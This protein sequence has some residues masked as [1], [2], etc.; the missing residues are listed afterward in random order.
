MGDLTLVNRGRF[1]SNIVQLEQ[2]EGGAL[3]ISSSFVIRTSRLNLSDYY[4]FLRN[5]INS[6]I[7]LVS[8]AFIPKESLLDEE[9]ERTKEV[10]DIS[11][12][13]LSQ[14]FNRD[15]IIFLILDYKHLNILEYHNGGI[16]TQKVPFVSE[17][18]DINNGLFDPYVVGRE[19]YIDSGWHELF[20]KEVY[21]KLHSNTTVVLMGEVIWGNA[22]NNMLEHLINR[23]ENDIEFVI[24]KYGVLEALLYGIPKHTNL[25]YLDKSLFVPQVKHILSNKKTLE[26][27]T[28][29]S[30]KRQFYLSDKGN[31]IELREDEFFKDVEYKYVLV[32][33]P[34]LKDID[35]EFDHIGYR[36]RQD[37]FIETGGEL[38]IKF[39]YRNRNFVGDL[40]Y[41]SRI[42]PHVIEGE[43]VKSG[44]LLGTYK[45][46]LFTREIKSNISGN[47][48]L[49]H[50]N[51]G[52]IEIMHEDSNVNAHF[53]SSFTVRP[54]I[55]LGES[56]VGYYKK[57]IIFVPEL[58]SK[59]I[60]KFVQ[61]S[62]RAILC[63]AIEE[64]LFRSVKKNRLD[65]VFT[66]V[67]LDGIDVDVSESSFL[68]IIKSG[69]LM[70][71]SE[72]DNII[73]IGISSVSKVL[74]GKYNRNDKYSIGKNIRIIDPNF[75]GKY[76]RI[77][78]R[79]DEIFSFYSEDLGKTNINIINLM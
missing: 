16:S 47:V 2:D 66:I 46:G 69:T 54:R 42:N 4:S 45:K 72:R 18:G 31:S 68:D 62:P 67:V 14:A 13:V 30:T 73:S 43:Y 74:A 22:S 27:D 36:A 51:L 44:Q 1:F 26:I 5:N 3:K 78:S 39:N 6:S 71:I 23:S 61:S 35:F 17:Y 32:N 10:R 48:S 29:L 52:I 38:V 24:D 50:I 55:I 57:D 56:A 28:N 58:T 75:W 11:I 7:A 65:N 25:H 64:A 20:Q 12:E 41:G 15:N 77:V 63:G 49:K 33:R 79:Q 19:E 37:W 8:D 60:S 40:N 76:A 70:N 53:D 34:K 21:K 9:I 59:N